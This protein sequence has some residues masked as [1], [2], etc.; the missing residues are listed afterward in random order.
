MSR[1]MGLRR[2]LVAVAFFVGPVACDSLTTPEEHRQ[3]FQL[4][5]GFEP[6]SADT[7]NIRTGDTL[8]LQVMVVTMGSEPNTAPP[9]SQT[10]ASASNDTVRVLSETAGRFRASRVGRDTILVEAVVQTEAAGDQILRGA[11]AL[12]V[13][14]ELFHGSFNPTVVL[15]GDT[16]KIDAPTE[17][18]QAQWF[19]ANTQVNF[20]P[21]R[22][23]TDLLVIPGFVISRTDSSSLRALVPAGIASG[24]I[25]LT[26]IAP[27]GRQLDSDELLSRHSSD[28]DLDVS[29]PNNSEGDAKPIAVPLPDT[30]LSVHR[31][32][33]ED[34][35]EFSPSASGAFTITLTWNVPANLD[36]ELYHFE[37]CNPLDLTCIGEEKETD[38]RAQS[39]DDRGEQATTTLDAGEEYFLRVYAAESLVAPTTYLLTIE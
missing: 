27:D 34:Y 6:T 38:S 18:G 37:A 3:S 39:Q 15:F 31:D 14:G 33:D 9:K 7:T 30:L 12:T 28:D 20:T 35:F 25:T 8:D 23:S 1:A 29:E 21:D 36:F 2:A 4:L 26:E 16:I 19:S 11:R 17:L 13:T 5:I 24:R 32:T 10:W 22:D